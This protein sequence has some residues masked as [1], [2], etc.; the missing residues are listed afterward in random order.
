MSAA[1]LRTVGAL[2]GIVGPLLLAVYFAAPALTNW[3]YAGASAKQLTAYALDHSMLFYAGAWFQVTGTVLSI[4][5]F[6]VI[7]YLAGALSRVFGVVTIMASAVLLGVVLI[8]AA[9][10]IAVPIAAANGDS[11]TVATT[12]AL[13]N[14][15]FVRVFPLAP[16]SLSFLGLGAVILEST[17]LPRAFGCLALGIGAAFELAGIAAIFS[18]LGL[19]LAIILSI[20]QEFWTLAAAIALA[21]SGRALERS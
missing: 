1:R 10:L 17:V 4:F 12:F 15:V 6:I 14:G 9:F 7:V 3:P 18:I 19:I 11:A 2:C 8:E 5:L 20:G 21:R 13:S 16:A